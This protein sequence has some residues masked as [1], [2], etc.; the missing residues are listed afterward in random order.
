LINSR[1]NIPKFDVISYDIQEL[2]RWIIDVL[3]V[4]LLEER[5]IK[6]SD[7]IIT[8]NYHIRLDEDV[9]KLLIEKI[10][11]TR[12]LYNYSPDKTYGHDFFH[13]C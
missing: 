3:A 1:I 7:F 5:K 11:Q 6:K 2:F 10:N 9:A 4:Q 12:F 8:E 13:T